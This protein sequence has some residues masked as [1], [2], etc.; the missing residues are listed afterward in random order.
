M[1]Q[2][3]RMAAAQAR[4][5]LQEAIGCLIDEQEYLE[6][7][8]SINQKDV[9]INENVT[10]RVHFAQERLKNL[11]KIFEKLNGVNNWL[12]AFEQDK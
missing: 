5:E 6:R 3:E 11:N 1:K 7:L 8:V 12:F 10:Q 9:D 2:I 4:K